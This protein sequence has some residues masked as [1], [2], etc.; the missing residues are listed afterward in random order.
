MP[1]VPRRSRHV[2]APALP[3][4]A[5]AASRA[6][7]GGGRRAAPRRVGRG[8]RIASSTVRRLG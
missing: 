1:L 2:Q 3:V 5:G 6:M 7:L 4:D 8:P